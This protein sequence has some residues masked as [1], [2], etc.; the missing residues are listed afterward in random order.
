MK[1]EGKKMR[2][3]EMRSEETKALFTDGIKL[4]DRITST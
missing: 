1:G 3:E 4:V 2:Q